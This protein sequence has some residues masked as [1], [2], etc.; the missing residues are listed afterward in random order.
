[1]GIAAKACFDAV[2]A[3]CLAKD[4]AVEESPWGHVVWKVKGKMFAV[5]SENEAR[6]TLKSNPAR[7][8]ALILHPNIEAAAYVGRFGWVTVTIPDQETLDL[9][10]ELIDEAYA[11]IK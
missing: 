4:G 10:L 6:V 2:R 7:Q 11:S 5:G 8:S 1:M 9:T 3:H